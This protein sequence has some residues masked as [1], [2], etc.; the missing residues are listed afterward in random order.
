MNE[1]I[2]TKPSMEQLEIL[3]YRQGM[4][5]GYLLRETLRRSRKLS[6][7]K[8]DVCKLIDEGSF[9]EIIVRSCDAPVYA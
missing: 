1:K 9:D 4:K 6:M 7:K 3:I 8:L 2:L 5:D